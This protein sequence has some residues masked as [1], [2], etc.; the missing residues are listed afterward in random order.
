MPL[1]AAEFAAMSKV[2]LESLRAQ[3]LTALAGKLTAPKRAAIQAELAMV[4]AQIKQINI[5]K[6][7]ADKAAADR[8]RSLGLA[9]HQENTERALARIDPAALAAVAPSPP[10]TSTYP[11]GITTRGELILMRAEQLRNQLRRCAQPME[12]SLA[13]LPGLEAFVEVQ[14][15]VVAKEKLER[16]AA[17]KTLRA[18]RRSPATPAPQQPPD[19]SWSETW[20]DGR[21]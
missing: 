14:K 3:H 5:D 12:H 18:A 8:R 7:R 13:L 6:S 19:P 11:K 9:E 21:E 20:T 4:N 15:A 17:E 10:P 1:T 2:E 16:R